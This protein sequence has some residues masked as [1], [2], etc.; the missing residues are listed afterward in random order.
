MVVSFD[1]ASYSILPELNKVTGFQKKTRYHCD[2][3]SDGSFSWC[4][5][6]FVVNE[7]DATLAMMVVSHLHHKAI[8]IRYKLGQGRFLKGYL[9][10]G[11]VERY[12]AVVCPSAF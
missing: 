7:G 5:R 10:L 1:G 12:I 4:A 3:S 9:A 2:Q 11:C 8:C 6:L